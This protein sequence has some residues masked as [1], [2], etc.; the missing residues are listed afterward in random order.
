MLKGATKLARIKG[1]STVI[2][3]KNGR[4]FLNSIINVGTKAGVDNQEL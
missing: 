3:F 4:W 2:S 1:V